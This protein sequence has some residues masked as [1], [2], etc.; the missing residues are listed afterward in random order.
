MDWMRNHILKTGVDT[1]M[2]TDSEL[3]RQVAVFHIAETVH[4]GIWKNYNVF[5]RIKTY[6]VVD[7][8]HL[9]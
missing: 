4:S 7:L 2:H 9:Q 5:K 3:I 1:E 8:K 6:V